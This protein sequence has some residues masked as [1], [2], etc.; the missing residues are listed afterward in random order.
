VLL[1]VSPYRRLVYYTTGMANLKNYVS[2]CV[3]W[4]N[5]RRIVWLSGRRNF[6]T[7]G[8]VYMTNDKEAWK[9]T[10]MEYRKQHHGF[11]MLAPLN[12]F[13]RQQQNC[14]LLAL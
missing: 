13:I 6:E 9:Q 12:V 4:T 2:C 14:G 8:E 10:E 5:D 1:T 11:I 3:M 7:T